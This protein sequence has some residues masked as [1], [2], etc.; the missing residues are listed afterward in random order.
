MPF[1]ALAQGASALTQASI[2]LHAGVLDY[3][4]HA[5]DDADEE[6]GCGSEKQDRKIDADF[7]EARQSGGSRRY[8]HA[9]RRKSKRQSDHAARNSENRT[10]KQKAHR[11]VGASGAKSRTNGQFLTAAFNPHE[12]QIGD[13]GAGNQQYHH[14]RSHEDPE[15][16]A[17]IANYISLERVNV[18]VDLDFFEDRCTESIWRREA[19]DGDRQ[20]AIQIRVG[21]FQGSRRV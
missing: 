21:L 12:Q 2:D 11:D 4:K 14:N 18:C 16:I 15:N 8:E 6:H 17:Y 3:R 9:Q 20:Q 10:L 19:V 13:V 7:V 1:A 5:D